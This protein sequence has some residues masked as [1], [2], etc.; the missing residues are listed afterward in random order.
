MGQSYVG[1]SGP[2]S[3]SA[4]RSEVPSLEAAAASVASTV[5][6]LVDVLPKL[7]SCRGTY[8]LLSTAARVALGSL[9]RARASMQS[10]SAA[11]A[12]SIIKEVDAKNST[13][14][15]AVNA[16]M[17]EARRTVIAARAVLF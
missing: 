7:A 13:Q 16:L 15:D 5:S 17:K 8:I 10:A 1:E 11:R 12:T 2:S 3:S 14:V 6:E 9:S 4:L